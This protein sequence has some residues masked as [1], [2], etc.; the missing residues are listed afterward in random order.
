MY[1]F[2]PYV[3]MFQCI[4]FHIVVW[5]LF[6]F[7]SFVSFY[8]L[9]NF[10]LYCKNPLA[11]NK[12]LCFGSYVLSYSNFLKSFYFFHNNIFS[13]WNFPHLMDIFWY[14]YFVKISSKG[15]KSKDLGGSW[16]PWFNIV[17]WIFG[18]TTNFNSFGAW[19][20]KFFLVFNFDICK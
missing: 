15:T 5:I 9:I 6:Q 8:N 3:Q 20:V 12:C 17:S 19:N 14:F 1:L 18:S 4:Q 10:V 13:L 7:L 2:W 16:L 11:I